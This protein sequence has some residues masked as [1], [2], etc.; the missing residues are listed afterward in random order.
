MKMPAGK[1][2]ND[3]TNGKWDEEKKTGPT[4]NR[5][6]S[7][8]DRLLFLDP[9]FYFITRVAA[10][11]TAAIRDGLL[12]SARSGGTDGGKGWKKVILR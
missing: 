8:R 3:N 9:P 11:A 2:R 7:E 12:Y 5:Q 10:A 4:A 1:G 6:S